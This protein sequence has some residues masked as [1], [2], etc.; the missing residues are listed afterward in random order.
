[1]IQM[2]ANIQRS[3]RM[4]DGMQKKCLSLTAVQ[5]LNNSNN[6]SAYS[7]PSWTTSP[8][9]QQQQ[10]SQQGQSWNFNNRNEQ[11]EGNAFG[12]GRGAS[13]NDMS[14]QTRFPAHSKRN[15]WR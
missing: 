13:Q 9:A 12:F 14:E 6:Q 3:M 2:D 5:S 10:Q 7:N 1:M 8:H 11:N 15:M 4:V